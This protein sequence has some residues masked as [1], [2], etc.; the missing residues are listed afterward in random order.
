MKEVFVGVGRYAHL[1]EQRKNG[2]VFS[3]L[4]CEFDS[5]RGV[6]RGVC[7]P[8]FRYAHGGSYKTLVVEVKK[9]FHIVVPLRISAVSHYQ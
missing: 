6:E 5:A 7:H 1:G 2:I 4:L 8:H 9:L 3:G